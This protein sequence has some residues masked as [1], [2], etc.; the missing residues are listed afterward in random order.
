MQGLTLFVV[1]AV[2]AGQPAGPA[3]SNATL[4]GTYGLDGSG[5]IFQPPNTPPLPVAG[6]FVR[7]GAVYFDGAGHVTYDTVSSYNGIVTQEPYQGGYTVSPDCRYEYHAVLPPPINLPTTFA[8]YVSANGDRVDYMLRNPDGAAVHATLIRQPKGHC[9]TRDLVG[10]YAMISSGQLLPPNSDAVP[11]VRAGTMSASVDSGAVPS[12]RSPG[13]FTV[14]ATANYAGL[15]LDE[16]FSGTFSVGDDCKVHFD[17]E[18][19]TS[20]GGVPASMDGIVVDGNK[21]I[22]FMISV[23]GVVV[24]GT[25]TRR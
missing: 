11:F 9:Q 8:G 3:C 10:T 16:T 22:I 5:N 1:L 25:M 4:K 20:S 18:Q 12:P 17:Y 2:A 19:P 24:G 15:N 23:Q 13:T 6:P 7:V 21:Q 14:T